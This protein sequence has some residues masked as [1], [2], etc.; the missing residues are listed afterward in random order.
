LLSIWLDEELALRNGESANPKTA[1]ERIS[2][3]LNSKMTL[4]ENHAKVLRD[5]WTYYK[6]MEITHRKRMRDF[7]GQ[8]PSQQVDYL[9]GVRR[10]PDAVARQIL[11]A[12][13]GS[14]YREL[15]RCE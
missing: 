6:T 11:D 15:M 5:R 7:P 8:S 13:N 10:Q 9:A 3:F 12:T 4:P 2:S 14:T 1:G